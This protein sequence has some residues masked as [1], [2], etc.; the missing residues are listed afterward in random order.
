VHL[1][2]RT[3]VIR[4][5]RIAMYPPYSTAIPAAN[6]LRLLVGLSRWAYQ[7]DGW[8]PVQADLRR[9]SLGGE[10]LHDVTLVAAE[11]READLSGSNLT[12]ADLRQ[13]QLARCRF[14]GA[15]LDR[16]VL[17]GVHAQ[18][19]SHA[20]RKAV[21]ESGM[22]TAAGD[23]LEDRPCLD[24]IRQRIGDLGEGGEGNSL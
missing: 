5:M 24:W 12:G 13:A 15:C 6:A 19:L 8:V 3:I 11:L 7:A 10:D 4:K 20:E 14:V 16:A 21:R 1:H 17:T 18:R 2:I 9:V 23:W 22:C